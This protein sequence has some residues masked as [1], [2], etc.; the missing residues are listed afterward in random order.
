MPIRRA[1]STALVVT[2]ALAVGA[3]T[4]GAISLPVAGSPVAAG[5]CATTTQDGQGRTGG[6]ATQVC[7]GGGLTFIGP[8]VGQIAT[9]IGPTILG[10]GFVANS[11]VSAGNVAV[12]P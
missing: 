12:G 9:V 10:P 3:P 8:S 2:A 7:S 4:A 5:P 1:L 6:T 11:I